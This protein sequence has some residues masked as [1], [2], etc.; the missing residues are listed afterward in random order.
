MKLKLT[1]S[2]DVIITIP[3]A[4]INEIFVGT[5]E[6]LK[7]VG[8]EDAPRQSCSSPRKECPGGRG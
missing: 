3:G 1:L 5:D 6:G 7:E 2:F 8:P 4:N